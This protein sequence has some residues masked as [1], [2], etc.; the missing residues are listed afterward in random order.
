[1][2]N[3]L[4]VNIGNTNIKIGYKK[5]NELITASY[6]SAEFETNCTILAD[7]VFTEIYVASVVP[8]RNAEV[9]Q[10]LEQQ[11]GLVPTFLTAQA[12][13]FDLSGYDAGKVGMDRL[14]ACKGA[15]TTPCVVFDLGTAISISVV[16]K[17]NV[18]RGGAILPG[19]T[20]NLEALYQKAALLPK[21]EVE[22]IT[23]V[24]A[25]VGNTTKACM[26]SGLVYGIASTVDGMARRIQK[27]MNLTAAN[28]FITGGFAKY[29]NAHLEE[30]YRYNEHMVIEGVLNLTTH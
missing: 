20:M 24:T 13:G 18:F 19:A 15:N 11:T 17:D 30:N 7:V 16:D 6:P 14:M 5:E 9:A 21:I 22:D 8:D 12:A 10:F 28:L 1:M 4:A 23:A 27:E 29:I 3:R 2:S 25:V 26:V